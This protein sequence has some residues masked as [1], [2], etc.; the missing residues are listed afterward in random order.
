[1]GNRLTF[2]RS[3]FCLVVTAAVAAGWGGVAPSS[4]ESIRMQALVNANGSGHL[5]VNTSPGP[6]SWEACTSD[7]TDCEPFGKGREIETGHA[8]PGTVFR[9][10]SRESTGVSPEWRGRVTQ[11]KAPRVHGPI[12]ANEF[13]SPMA[14]MWSG[15]W[16]GEYSALQLSACATSTGQ[17]CTSLTDPHYVRDCAASASFVLDAKFVG[18]FL[19]VANR[20]LGAGPL[21]SPPYATSSPH[22]AEVWRSS[23][24]TSVAVVGQISPAVNDH[25]GECGPPP[26]GRAL[27]SRRGVAFIDCQGGCRAALIAKRNGRYIRVKRNLSPRNALL[28]TPPVELR[29]PVRTI[30]ARFGEGRV[31]LVVRI[32][33]K[34]VAQ[35]TTRFDS[36]SS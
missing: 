25:P 18:S 1:M 10:K 17:G 34:Q 5:F 27:L 31:R 16:K 36:S 23:R 19:R 11:I 33:G 6:W 3:L 13:I 12:R 24:N 29:A 28:V 9:V 2:T 4:A 14:G 15:G 32:N 26:P 22:G 30:L 8:A 35:R 20:R 21:F 7:L